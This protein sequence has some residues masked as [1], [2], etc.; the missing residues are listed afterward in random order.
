[1]CDWVPRFPPPTL[2]Q[3]D[4]EKI[5]PHPPRLLTSTNYKSWKLTFA[6]ICTHF[7]RNELKMLRYDKIIMIYFY[8]IPINIHF[9]IFFLFFEN[10]WNYYKLDNP[11]RFWDKCKQQSD[12][13]RVSFLLYEVWNQQKKI[14]YMLYA[15][16]NLVELK[17]LGAGL[18]LNSKPSMWISL[19]KLLFSIICSRKKIYI[20][21]G[22]MWYL[23]CSFIY[24]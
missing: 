12:P 8:D 24:Y 9:S 5:R 10:I 14:F 21:K 2:Q 6:S 1:M 18:N 22:I 23:F 11:T 19:L 4:V 3:Y 13:I 17:I 15:I 20:Y 16:K 7:V